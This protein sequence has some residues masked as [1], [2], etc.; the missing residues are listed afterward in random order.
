MKVKARDLIAGWPRGRTTIRMPGTLEITL[1]PTAEDFVDHYLGALYHGDQQRAVTE[2]LERWRLNV[3][4][5]ACGTR[6]Y[7]AETDT[8]S[9]PRCGQ[10]LFC[11]IA[12]G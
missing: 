5:H 6:F 2:Y 10:F 8:C 11:Q 4:C 1:F 12:L 9:C 7:S 3:K